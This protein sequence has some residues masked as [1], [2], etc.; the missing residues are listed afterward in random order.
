MPGAPAVTQVNA[1]DGVLTVGWA[2]PASNGGSPIVRYQVTAT[3][4]GARL[5]AGGTA[6]SATLSGQPDGVRE[7]VQVQAVKRVG[8]GPSVPPVSPA[9]LPSRT[10]R[11]KSRACR[12]APPAPGQISLSW[13]QPSLGPYHTP[14]ANY[15]VRGGPAVRTVTT[16]Q[17]V[18]M[19]LAAGTAYSF[20]I[21]ATN[22]KRQHRSGQRPRAGHHLV[23]TLGRSP[24][25]P[26]PEATISSPS[27]GRRPRCQAAAPL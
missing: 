15:S 1:G 17:A 5:S 4:S 16:T 7:C 20:T 22:T 9:P 19:R 21:V 2:P 24:T 6:T 3:P 18:V 13:R 23:D 27:P 11:V 8:G 14:I 12:P 10:R 26:S 25:S